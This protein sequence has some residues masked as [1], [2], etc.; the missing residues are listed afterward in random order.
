[1]SNVGR[2]TVQ[3]VG[4]V[5]LLVCSLVSVHQAAEAQVG[6]R[7]ESSPYRD[8]RAK[9]ALSFT[10]AYLTGSRGKAGVGPGAGPYLGARFDM[11]FTGPASMGVTA[12]LANLDR[13]VIDPTYG[14]ANR[15]QDTTTQA[16]FMVD[17]G[18]DLLLTGEKSW[19]SM[20]PYIGAGLGLA[21]GT[22]VEEDSLSGFSF[23][24]QFTAGPRLGIWVQ[25]SDRIS[26]R[27]EAADVIWKLS[28]PDGFFTIPENEPTAPPVLDANVMKDSQWVHH[29]RLSISLGYAI[30]N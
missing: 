8:L 9:K 17:A 2:I 12:G 1:M 4:I 16:I 30:G 11:H 14:P 27:V 7:P 3:R 28:Y 15:T 24:V 25:P 21:F 6:N 22:S 19:H 26:F 5:T 20:I 13:V 23:A 29:L 10:G 18:F